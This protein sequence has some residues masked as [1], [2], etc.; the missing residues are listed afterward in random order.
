MHIKKSA[1]ALL[2]MGNIVGLAVLLAVAPDGMAKGHQS[3]ASDPKHAQERWVVGDLAADNGSTVAV[4]VGNVASKGALRRT[5]V[6]MLDGIVLT[7]YSYRLDVRIRIEHDCQSGQSTILDY[8][9]YYPSGKVSLFS[10]DKAASARR[11]GLTA[12]FPDRLSPIAEATVQAAVCEVSANDRREFSSPKEAEELA[13]GTRRSNYPPVALERAHRIITENY[14]VVAEALSKVADGQCEKQHRLPAVLEKRD[15]YLSMLT[16][17]ADAVLAR[18]LHA[19]ADAS[20]GA[21]DVMRSEATAVR[22][23]RECVGDT[24]P[25]PAQGVRIPEAFMPVAK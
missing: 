3:F 8:P 10:K 16:N 7:T 23:A 2:W 19:G 22:W 14:Q 1:T 15:I 4:E 6:V 5:S 21:D 18:G 17:S 24:S 25:L 9:V 11:S 12:Q 20:Y 13:L